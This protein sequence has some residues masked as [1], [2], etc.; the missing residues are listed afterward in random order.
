MKNVMTVK[1]EVERPGPPPL[2]PPNH[3]QK[4]TGEVAHAHDG[5]VQGGGEQRRGGGLPREQQLV[6]QRHHPPQAQRREQHTAEGL[7]LQRL[8]ALQHRHREAAQAQHTH[9]PQIERAPERHALEAVEDDR[10]RRRCNEDHN[11]RVIEPPD[12]AGELLGDTVQGVRDGGEEQAQYGARQE[13]VEGPARRQ[14][15][16]RQHP[17][18]PLHQQCHQLE[19]VDHLFLDGRH[20]DEALQL[21]AD[22]VA[23][24]HLHALQLP[25]RMQQ[26]LPQ[27]QR[28]VELHECVPRGRRQLH[29]S[30]SHYEIHRQ[31]DEQQQPDQM[32]PNVHRLIVQPKDGEESLPFVAH[33]GTVATHDV[34]VIA[35]PAGRRMPGADAQPRRIEGLN[36]L[37]RGLYF[38]V[39]FRSPSWPPEIAD[40]AF[41]G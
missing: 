38:F 16:R 7:V 18:Q 3:K 24:L 4:H 30:N 29:H 25:A 23:Q 17:L 26:R 11:P 32:R 36:D 19:I 41:T 14:H 10:H 21:H 9:H 27:C 13:G 15:L 37:C 1:E 40:G 20:V 28:V 34:F 12:K 22:G 39:L 35:Q 33:R 6:A 2:R 31:A 8:E 5:L